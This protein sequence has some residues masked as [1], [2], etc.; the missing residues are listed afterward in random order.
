MLIQG[1]EKSNASGGYKFFPDGHRHTQIQQALVC[2]ELITFNADMHIPQ[3]VHSILAT[4]LL[5][6][7]F[8]RLVS[9]HRTFPG[10][11]LYRRL[12]LVLSTLMF[13]FLATP[14]GL[15]WSNTNETGLSFLILCT[16]WLLTLLGR[17]THF[18]RKDQR[19]PTF[20]G[21]MIRQY[22]S[23]NSVDQ[24]TPGPPVDHSPA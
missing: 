14:V 23:F 18:D 21:G 1:V 7:G 17:G 15:R 4:V 24:Q 6:I 2:P 10:N 22:A 19:I 11:V 3:I 12:D 9:N 5:C 13:I 20:A 8:G 16:M